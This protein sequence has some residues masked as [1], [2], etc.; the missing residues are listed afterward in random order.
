MVVL[1]RASVPDRSFAST[2]TFPASLSS[3]AFHNATHAKI[4]CRV[5]W[6]SETK[7]KGNA[8]AWSFIEARSLCSR[9]LV[10]RRCAV[11]ALG[12]PQCT[13]AIHTPLGMLAPYS[14]TQDK[15]Q[16][17]VF[18]AIRLF[19]F[20]VNFF[21]FLNSTFCATRAMRS[22]GRECTEH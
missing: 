20:M 14:R 11:T 10:S 22:L 1:V 19:Y 15:W 12:V 6:P 3:T 21:G 17:V 8:L 16:Y 18:S 5:K 9:R 4:S 2:F 13:W 7:L